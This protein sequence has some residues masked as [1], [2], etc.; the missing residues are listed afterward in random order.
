ML[1]LPGLY[2]AYSDR[3]SKTN[4]EGTELP[5]IMSNHLEYNKFAR[6]NDWSDNRNAEIQR[7]HE[8]C[9]E[10]KRTSSPRIPQGY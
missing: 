1:L 7:K 2:L 10:G 6:G 5:Y 4:P 9:A 8:G 3:Y